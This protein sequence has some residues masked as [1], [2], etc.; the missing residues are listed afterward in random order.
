[1]ILLQRLSVKLAYLLIKQF[2]LINSFGPSVLA[3]AVQVVVTQHPVSRQD[4]PPTQLW[5][6]QC[7]QAWGEFSFMESRV[8]LARS[9]IRVSHVEIVVSITSTMTGPQSSIKHMKYLVKYIWKW[10][11]DCPVQIWKTSRDDQWQW[12]GAL[13]SDQLQRLSPRS[14]RGYHRWWDLRHDYTDIR[15]LTRNLKVKLILRPFVRRRRIMQQGPRPDRQRDAPP[16]SLRHY[17][18]YKSADTKLRIMMRLLIARRY[19]ANVWSQG[20]WWRLSQSGSSS[21]S[22]KQV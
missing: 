11:H 19:A 21:Y 14:S 5:L 15:H 22:R 17:W 10:S 7:C 13:S 1:M 18:H 12:L 8:C 3:S 16:P 6:G 4:S 9:H 20:Q 2:Y